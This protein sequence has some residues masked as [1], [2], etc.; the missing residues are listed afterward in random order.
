MADPRVTLTAHTNFPADLLDG[1]IPNG[2]SGLLVTSG[3]TDFSQALMTAE[4]DHSHALVA[5]SPSVPDVEELLTASR[6]ARPDMALIVALPGPPNGFIVQA[7][8]AGAHEIVILPSDGL[9]I[10]SAVHTALAR[11]QSRIDEPVTKSEGKP[12]PVVVV[13]GPK[14]GVGKTTISSNLATDLARRGHR[15]LLIDLDL[16][17]GD[18]GLVLGIEPDRTIFDLVS[19]PGH[20]DGEKLRGFLRSS[21]DGVDVLLAPVRPDQAE[22]VT[23]ENLAQLMDVAQTQYDVVV[24]DTPPAFTATTIA[25]IDRAQHA[26][27][28]GALDLPG[29]KNLKVGLET[30]DLMGFPRDRVTVALNR[31]DSK[32]GLDWS[33]VR[34]ILDRPPDIT[35]PSDR[36]LPRSIN[37]TRPLVVTEPK[38]APAKSLRQLTDRLVTTLLQPKDA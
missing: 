4:R 15:T 31:A 38:S 23:P 33:D 2:S 27:M 22:A 37:T 16:Q 24:V 36:A 26:V 7:L 6:E 3:L 30:M 18:V 11:I 8:K 10:A 21:M 29:M 14:G 34:E 20:L 9:A 1:A 35:I 12:A 25:V 32:V 19:S 28:V 5:F 17:F 13:L